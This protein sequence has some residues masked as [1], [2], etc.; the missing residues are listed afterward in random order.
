MRKVNWGVV[1]TAGIAKGQTIPGMKMAQNCNLYAIAG[2]NIEKAN[3]F[4]EEFGFEKAYG[5]YDELLDD[6]N[7]E[8]VYL[9]LPNHVHLEWIKKAALKGKHILCEKPLCGT[10]EET[11]EAHAFCKEHGVILMEAFAYLHSEAI[12]EIVDKI[13]GGA[14]GNIRLMESCF[15]TGG[16]KPND[17]RWIHDW[18]GGSVY[19]L[20][21]YSISLILRIMN[22]LPNSIEAIGN[23]TEDEHVDDYCHMYLKFDG[24]A[25]ASLG[26]GFNGMYRSDRMV[27]HG[28]KGS[29]WADIEFNQCG[30]LHYWILTD[31]G[32]EDF[33]VDTTNN[34]QLEV[35]QLSKCVLG[36][37]TPRITEEFSV[38]VATVIE[39]V[40][41]KIGY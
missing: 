26:C 41:K 36:E 33:Y 23:F 22:K 21:C 6:P 14:I 3:A 35:E 39:E 13:N 29:L 38:M 24:T 31:D 15:F 27:F 2:R 18:Y 5:S 8:A 30:K 1:G 9:P 25:Q 34:Y 19:D 32:R 17:I 10:V 20:G 4:K 7:V 16:P 28:D 12:N 40:L 37:E 11:K